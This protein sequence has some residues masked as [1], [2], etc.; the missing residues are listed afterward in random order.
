M[1]VECMRNKWQYPL[2]SSG[3][4]RT[5]SDV[6]PDVVRNTKQCQAN[7]PIA[8]DRVIIT[9]LADG[10]IVGG[11]KRKERNSTYMRLNYI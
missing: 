6:I 5:N 3:G 11:K 7:P 10:Q 4:F 9:L 2:S 1:S 8:C